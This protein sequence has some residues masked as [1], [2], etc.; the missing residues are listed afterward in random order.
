[1]RGNCAFGIAKRKKCQ[2]GSQNNKTLK[3]N[4]KISHFSPC[5]V[6]GLEY[7]VFYPPANQK[8]KARSTSSLAFDGSTSARVVTQRRFSGLNRAR[9]FI[10][11][12][13]WFVSRLPAW[14]ISTKSLECLPDVLRAINIHSQINWKEFA[15]ESGPQSQGWS[16]EHAQLHVLLSSPLDRWAREFSDDFHF[17]MV[18]GTPDSRITRTSARRSYERTFAFDRARYIVRRVGD[19]TKLCYFYD[20]ISCDSSAGRWRAEWGRLSH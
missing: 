5:D 14:L 8:A 13:N 17:R 20:E 7:R 2:T 6:F 3:S 15:R 18:Q 11:V 19:C 10:V 16:G 1:M 4:N 9:L 12:H